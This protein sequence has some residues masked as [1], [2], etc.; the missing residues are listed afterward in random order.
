MEAPI[1]S[2]WETYG[3]KPTFFSLNTAL[4]RG[5]YADWKI[6]NSLLYL[7]GFYGEHLYLN[8]PA[9][10]TKI[11]RYNLSDLFPERI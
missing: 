10:I 7:I 3:N 2:Y 1:F 9:G 6:E 11:T 5:F 4:Q 8:L